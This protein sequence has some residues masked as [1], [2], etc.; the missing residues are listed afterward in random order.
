[1]IQQMLSKAN[2]SFMPKPNGEIAI[3][4]PYCRD[5]YGRKDFK[6]HLQINISKRTYYCYR[7]G[8]TGKLSQLFRDLGVEYVKEVEQEKVGVT[9][10]EMASS[11]KNI[12]RHPD[13]KI[14]NIIDFSFCKPILGDTSILGDMARDYLHKRNILDVDIEA[15]DLRYCTSGDYAFRIIIPFYENG[16]LVYF[17]SR[18]F[19][20]HP[21]KKVLNPTDKEVEIGKSNWLFNIDLARHHDPVIICEGWASAITVGADAVAIQGS[22]ASGQQIERLLRYWSSYVVMLDAEAKKEAYN[23]AGT[24]YK[25][26]TSSDIHIVF[27]SYGDPNNFDRKKLREYIKHA[28]KFDKMDA[29]KDLLQDVH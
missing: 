23:L 15:Y 4:C 5:Q 8:C 16:K 1:M 11:I 21:Y 24:L 10:S 27:L 17:Q 26:K 25:H 28:S 19:S 9:L 7:R 3:C 29:C 13:E 22:R 12:S 2:I 18:A 14:Q 20:M 6:Y